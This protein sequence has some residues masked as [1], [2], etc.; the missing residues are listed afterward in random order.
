MG[1]T[2]R[3]AT[4]NDLPVIAELAERIWRKHYV[5]I[6]GEK[7]TEY[8]L[9]KMY[10][11]ESLLKQMREQQNFTLAYDDDVPVG[12]ISISKKENNNYFLHKFYVDTEKQRTG[13]GSVFFENILSTIPDAKTIELT[14]NRINYKAINFYFKKGFIIKEVADFDIGE[15]F[16]MND[17]VMR[18]TL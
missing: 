18:R 7:Q 12:Y 10:S 1:L 16:F 8:M 4:E 6:I 9:K 13:I 15:G 14:V 17:F 3:K 5:P 2:F 11:A